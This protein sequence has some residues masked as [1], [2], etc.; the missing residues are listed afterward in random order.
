MADGHKDYSATPLWRKLG[1]RQ[2]SRVVVVGGPAEL[3]ELLVAQAPL[4]SGVRRLSRA[5]GRVDVAVLFTTERRA[6]ERRFG[7]LQRSLD[8]AGR[9]WVAWPKKA[10]K[11]PT[12]LSFEVVQRHG[13]DAGLVDN[14]TASITDVFQGC[15][16]VYR[17]EDR[18]RED[19]PRNRSVR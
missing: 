8:P 9:L 13:L 7:S 18:S 6:L 19:R 4:P 1:I 15:Q 17:R 14:K 11:V 3:D 16:F 10:S 5:I 2:G 12:D